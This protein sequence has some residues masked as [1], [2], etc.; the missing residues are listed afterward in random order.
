MSSSTSVEITRLGS[1]ASTSVSRT[2]RRVEEKQ[3]GSSGGQKGCPWAAS[4]QRK[5]TSSG[6]SRMSML[7]RASSL[8]T[9]TVYT[10]PEIAFSDR[11]VS[12]DATAR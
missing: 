5:M 2:V 6:L 3:K 9:A 11:V 12:W 1:V 8:S 7:E 4:N 10:S